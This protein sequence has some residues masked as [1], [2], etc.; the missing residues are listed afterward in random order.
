VLRLAQQPDLVRDVNG[1]GRVGAGDVL[2]FRA[3]MT[4]QGTA[5]SRSPSVSDLFLARQ[6]L[7]VTCSAASLAVGQSTS[8]VS[9]EL[10]VTAEMA[11]SGSLVNQMTPRGVTASGAVIVGATSSTT[12]ALVVPAVVAPPLSGNGHPP[13]PRQVKRLDLS[14]YRVSYDDVNGNGALTAGETMV[15][16]FEALN[17]GTVTLDDLTI[18]DK[19]LSDD[20]VTITCA[21]RTLAPGQRVLCSTSAIT[22]TDPQAKVLG[23]GF[24][25]NF[26]YATAATATGDSVRS[27]TSTLHQGYFISDVQGT[28]L[29]T[30]GVA[31]VVPVGIGLGLLLLGGVALALS[32]GGRVPRA[33]HRWRLSLLRLG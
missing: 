33:R 19:R 12:V 22:I 8:C 32:R 3:T 10:V 29:P 21:T 4:N 1:D 26:A 7:Q 14:Q 11:R 23:T 2:V 27:P 6:G 31:L 18:V 25:S 24:G 16:G 28:A 20:K 17:T 9:G 13:T 15:I 5:S 30:T